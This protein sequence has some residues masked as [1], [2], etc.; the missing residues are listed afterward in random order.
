M[1]SVAPTPKYYDIDDIYRLLKLSNVD[2]IVLGLWTIKD[3]EITVF[4]IQ[5]S[6]FFT[7][8][9]VITD[10]CMNGDVDIPEGRT[11]DDAI[12][13]ITQNDIKIDSRGVPHFDPEKM[14]PEKVS[15][16]ETIERFA[17]KFFKKFG[18]NKSDS[19]P[20]IHQ[21]V[22]VTKQDWALS[23]ASTGPNWFGHA[24]II[25]EG[26][27]EDDKRFKEM[28]HIGSTL[29]SYTKIASSK[30]GGVVEHKSILNKRLRLHALQGPWI[31]PKSKVKKML[32]EV[33][34][35]QDKKVTVPFRMMSS[36]QDLK[37]GRVYN[38]LTWAVKKLEIAGIKIEFQPNK[39]LA[40]PA[41]WLR[42]PLNIAVGTQNA[43]VKMSVQKEP[44]KKDKT[45]FK[46]G[47]EYTK[48]NEAEPASESDDATESD[49][50]TEVDEQS[51][52]FTIDTQIEGLYSAP[53][54]T[55]TC[56]KKAEIAQALF[57]QQM[58]DREE[59][60]EQEPP[61]KDLKT[62]LKP[63]REVVTTAKKTDN[64]KF[65]DLIIDT[66]PP[67]RVEPLNN[68]TSSLALEDTD[69]SDESTEDVWKE[70]MDQIN[71]APIPPEKREPI[72]KQIISFH[73]KKTAIELTLETIALDFIFNT[74]RRRCS[75]EIL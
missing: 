34:K 38:C 61:R 31:V 39:S 51:E 25:I 47:I 2:A 48:N 66:T 28:A 46:K 12:E 49:F 7:S 11:I 20:K 44:T 18:K 14:K 13:L 24:V 69:N 4:R 75:C 23:L 17:D 59:R 71:R 37:E 50:D 42:K 1:T 15:H 45:E 54:D 56:K 58:Y 19:K 52:M 8:R 60:I 74:P 43:L 67:K 63:E 10:E 65:T 29:S 36:L 57:K 55:L 40:I 32:V 68:I 53:R 21:V 73:N 33:Q 22:E 5:N 70:A 41:F 30:W 27:G 35:E 6:L 62:P 3:R 64:V 16:Q 26:I 72:P 9:D